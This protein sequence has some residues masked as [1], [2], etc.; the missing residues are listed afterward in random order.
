MLLPRY[1]FKNRMMVHFS[2]L[3]HINC[4]DLAVGYDSKMFP[5][6]W[7]ILFVFFQTKKIR[8]QSDKLQHRQFPVSREGRGGDGH[9]CCATSIYPD[10]MSTSRTE[11]GSAMCI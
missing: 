6:I 8:L 10:V 5:R 7:S 3:F 4:D 11:T 2:L 9:L 1:F